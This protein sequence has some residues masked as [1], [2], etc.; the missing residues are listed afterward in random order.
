M[1]QTLRLDREE[2]IAHVTLDR[3]GSLNAVDSEMTREFSEVFYD[4][5]RDEETRVIV[6]SGNGDAFSVGALTPY[7]DVAAHEPLQRDATAFGEAGA[8]IGDIQ[9][10]NRGT[11]GGNL[12]HSDPASDLPGAV[13]ASD[14]TIHVQGRDGSREIAADDFFEGMYA[15]AVG[16]DEV[17]T[18][19]D[20]PTLDDGDVGAYVK[21][22]SPSS[23]YAM[24]GVA[25]QLDLDG[26]T[27][28]SA[29]VGANGAMDHGVRLDPEVLVRQEAA[30]AARP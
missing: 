16:D 10:R 2:G 1:Y 23:G 30:G 26:E 27:V 14:A 28:A 15:T 6:L 11:V 4:L 19:L 9:V 12:A 22:P 20:V 7:A 18:G 8:A 24:V 25:A 3:P 17:L 13:L 5:S 21:K 29:G